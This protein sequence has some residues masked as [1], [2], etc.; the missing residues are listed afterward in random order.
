MQCCTFVASAEETVSEETV[1]EET[2]APTLEGEL[3]E[4]RTANEKYFMYS[5]Q[6]TVAAVYPNAV[7]YQDEN[8]V[9]Q[10]I[11]NR[12]TESETEGDAELGNQAN[13][14]NVKF[15]KKAKSN[16]LAK[17][18]YGSHTIK[19]TLNGASKTEGKALQTS[20]S[21]TD[22]PT[23]LQGISSGVVY[24]DI[25]PDV[26]LEYQLL[27][28][29]IKENIIL[30]S[31]DAANEFTF[32]YETGSLEM[33]LQ[34]N[35]ILLMD[36]ENT[37]LKLDAPVMTDG[38]LE[39]SFDIS[40]SLETVKDNQNN[41]I[42]AL[43]L[44][45]DAK[46]L[47]EEDR[48]YPIIIDPLLTTEQSGDSIT[49]TYASSSE[50]DTAHYNATTTKVGINDSKVYR[51]YLKFE[52]PTQIGVS[53]R[54][55]G[56][57]LQL[58]PYL[59][60]TAYADYTTMA[61][62][63]PVIEAH[64]VTSTWNKTTL[65]WNNAPSH[66]STV[67]D[68]DIIGPK[69]DAT[70]YRRY[71]WDITDLVDDWYTSGNNYGVVFKYDNETSYGSNMVANFVSSNVTNTDK[72]YYPVISI[73]YMNMQGLEDYWTYHSLD[74]GVGGVAYINDFTGTMTSITPI[75]SVDSAITPINISLV[76]SPGSND[77]SINALNVGNGFMLNVQ[78]YIKKMPIGG[79]TKYKYVDEDGT[80]H[81]FEKNEDNNWVD[82][83]GIGLKLE[84]GSDNHIIRDKQDNKIYFYANNGRLNKYVDNQGNELQ[85]YY[86]V[87]NSA[88]YLQRIENG[89]HTVTFERDSQNRLLKVHYPTEN[90]GTRYA[91][92]NYTDATVS[93]IYHLTQYV[94]SGSTYVPTD[95]VG[96]TNSHGIVNGIISCP[97]NKENPP[98][99]ADN[100][101]LIGTAL[102][103]TYNYD[104][105]T[106]TL[107]R[108]VKTYKKQAYEGINSEGV[109]VYG[110]TD[111]AATITYGKGSTMYTSTL[112]ETR[113]ELYT[114]NR[115]GQT[116][117]A[118]D[119][120]GNAL[121]QSQGQSGGS[122]NKVTFTSTSQRAV[123]NLAINHNFE[124][125]T[126]S[127]STPNWYFSGDTNDNSAIRGTS[128]GDTPHLGALVM[129]VYKNSASST[130]NAAAKQS[131]TLQGGKV[132]TLS[133]YVKTNF[134]S[135]ADVEHAGASI[136]VERL[137]I[138]K[139]QF[140]TNAII[141]ASGYTRHF[142]TIDLSD[143]AEGTYN[144]DIILAIKRAKG[145][146]YFD[147]VQLEEG[148]AVNSYNIL[149][150]A[151]FEQVPSN[152]WTQVNPDNMDGRVQETEDHH[153][154]TY[155]YKMKGSPK[156]SRMLTQTIPLSGTKGD[157]FTAGVWVKTGTLPCKDT[158]LGTKQNCAI[159]LEIC[160]T[161]GTSTYYT[162]MLDSCNTE[163]R[164]I[165][166]GGVAARAYS[167][168]KVHLKY[169]YN[170]NITYFDDANL[171]ADT[172]GQSY[173][174]DANGN[175][176][177]VVDLA[178]TTSSTVVNGN[179]DLTSYTD[180][181]GNTYNFTYNDDTTKHQLLSATDPKNMK[182]SYSY[183]SYGNV[184]QVNTKSAGGL[185]M[186][187]LVN[188]TADGHHLKNETDTTGAL[189]EY[190]RDDTTGR[191]N[192]LYTP[193][194]TTGKKR[195][196]NYIYDGV[197]NELTDVD[198]G[199]YTDDAVYT[200]HPTGVSYDYLQGKLTDIARTDTNV[201]QIGYH[202]AYDSLGRTTG[203]SWSGKGNTKRSLQTT[204][205]Q[206]GTGLVETLTYAN[207]DNISYKYNKAG[208]TTHVYSDSTQVKGYE[209]NSNHNLG[210][211]W[212]LNDVGNKIGN[213]YF[214][215]LAGRIS[216]MQS[217][218]GFSTDAY[219]Y[220]LNN[221]LTSYHSALKD[222][223]VD[224]EFTTNYE[225]NTTNA[226][227][228]L[229]L[230]LRNGYPS[231]E[232]R[233]GYD[234]LGRL[235][236][237]KVVLIPDNATTPDAN[238]EV[239]L[240]TT[241][242][243]K[244]LTNPNDTE[245]PYRTLKPSTTY[246]TGT[247]DGVTVD[248]KYYTL[249]NPDGG[250]S[251]MR[252]TEAGEHNY[253]HY[254]YDDLGQLTLWRNTGTGSSIN[255][256]NVEDYAY[257][258][259][260]GG[261]LSTI[262][263]R[264]GTT[265]DYSVNYTYDSDFSDLL[266]SYSKT[267]SDGTITTR[268]YDYTAS[269]GNQFINPTTITHKT[270][271]ETTTTWTMD[272]EQGRQLSS[273]TI[274][275]STVNYDYNENGLRTLRQLANGA[276]RE[277][278]YNGTQ[279]EYIKIIN[280]SGNLTSTLRYIYNSSGQAEYIM[281]IPAAYAKNGNVFSLYYI[282][283]DCE[284]KIHKLIK[285]RQPN[286]EGTGIDAVLKVAVTYTYG[287]YGELLTTTKATGESVGTYNPLV[288]KDYIYD[289][290]TKW[291]Y[292]QS[293]YYDPVVGRFVNGD[294]LI[295]GVGQS[296]EGY[297]MFAYCMNDPINMSDP[298]GMWPKWI[299]NVA[300]WVN[301]NIVK[302]VTNFFVKTYEY[303]TNSDE[304]K[305]REDLK[306]HGV[307]FYKG[308]PVVTAPIETG[309]ATFGLIAM[310]DGNL[311]KSEFP[312]VLNHEY[313]HSVHFRQ[314]GAYTYLTT[315]AIPSLIGAGL[316]T[317]K[318]LPYQYYYNLPWERTADYLGGVNR[319]YLPG[320]TTVGRLFWKYTMF[321]SRILP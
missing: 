153:G 265:T 223:L 245:N 199:T 170:A 98:T 80:A 180:G 87:I 279:L 237:K 319:G 22:D 49:D 51:G 29:T 200:Q 189:T 186:Q 69:D 21:A 10:D 108:R 61:E 313:G 273:I 14:W 289:S 264:L 268:E 191:L 212:Y 113:T 182:T 220:D 247:Y 74:A 183:N 301:N 226:Q 84:V 311:S 208:L 68:Y 198:I 114:F 50:P 196:T 71:E 321:V 56:A 216:G 224:L 298:S 78:S 254:Q 260:N 65:T 59:T 315:T 228:K 127:D 261:N 181:K 236:N 72:G 48:V 89:K 239:S 132:Y 41:H 152:G 205:Y 213:H 275:G 159:T 211:S 91:Q 134:T 307:S 255:S 140:Y 123:T 46:W 169:S 116:I 67:L 165:C 76:Y 83:G 175:V 128:D 82:D 287:P 133:A 135:V 217:N 299:K 316:T 201:K 270:N 11:D 130:V 308:T 277:Y 234:G 15:A 62:K 63:A 310:G 16:K 271:G 58:T 164:Y 282:L 110:A 156:I 19:W 204:T 93:N 70:A 43:T 295:S 306:K 235:T 232:M 173:T 248:T 107:R 238:E 286:S 20:E 293:R 47:A 259:D 222:S 142:V 119:T 96:F 12:L 174:Y 155:G 225:Y 314:V 317:F 85:L 149:E 95:I 197:T 97:Y 26:N 304:E 206:E 42:Y 303:V 124:K 103:F 54:V 158:G 31:P 193:S 17:L 231:G 233:Y 161:N 219:L 81:Y 284:G 218:D 318:I 30:C 77:S 252:I 28:D 288:Y 291:Y 188:Y 160:G 305:T 168:V 27:G 125:G 138:P 144:Y 148:S 285:V 229:Y 297:N 256:T 192:V 280:A 249:Y 244:T 263:H 129:K 23:V 163:W 176:T 262:T 32:V 45:P 267:A 53:D 92:F 1:L 194:S 157:S 131:V 106:S 147:C 151:G 172:F 179:N 320:A 215:D 37:V 276:K 111:Y 221:N 166:V 167:S 294:C 227:T 36:G 190:T 278:I 171:F 243:Y 300:N 187:S 143:V 266:T 117:T 136:G 177:S 207:G 302:P 283:R 73:Q 203:I 312:E 269:N 52:L 250:L 9:W 121:F 139:A 18:K 241:I 99:T 309:A 60:D 246:M 242:T 38:A 24:E 202:F 122:K 145:I 184:T 240:A 154:G 33:K 86:T 102:R 230:N 185:L 8:G 6:S 101:A 178:N 214:Y 34:D 2:A 162:K 100:T 40:L 3:I 292:V 90:E 79:V 209:Y 118:Q 258:Y 195:V 39:E 112:G 251:R 296:V 7:H 35:V 13:A 55:V 120:E 281:Y 150:N 115:H 57:W 104:A 66:D 75:A 126:S 44:T 5:D 25:L 4:K 141:S 94:K 272:W 210:Y 290:E 64:A 88:Y 109:A 105:E 257:T 253:T 146:A 274:N 137:D